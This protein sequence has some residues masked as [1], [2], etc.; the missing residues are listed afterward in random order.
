MTKFTLHV[1]VH[2]CL[3]LVFMRSILEESEFS[4]KLRLSITE[5][6]F[7]SLTVLA[8]SGRPKGAHVRAVRACVRYPFWYADVDVSGHFCLVLVFMW[9][10]SSYAKFL[11]V[12][13]FMPSR[14]KAEECHNGKCQIFLKFSSGLYQ[15]FTRSSSGFHQVFIKS[16]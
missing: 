3:V 5:I 16:S 2:I 14:L 9:S 6:G 15:I 8:N 7:K 12:Y 13:S 10:I 4:L 11:L 1:S